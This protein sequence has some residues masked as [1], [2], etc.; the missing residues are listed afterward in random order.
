MSF[1]YGP[2]GFLSLEYMMGQLP[3]FHTIPTMRPRAPVLLQLLVFLKFMG[4]EG[5]DG[6]YAKI[7]D[8]LGVS[9]GSVANYVKRAVQGFME[10]RQQIIQ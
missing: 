9:I 6:S 10:I 1:S 4:T 2:R 8:V 5:T 7:G 3:A